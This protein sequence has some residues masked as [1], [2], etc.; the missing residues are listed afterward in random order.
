MRRHQEGV[1]LAIIPILL[2]V[3]GLF[4]AYMARSINQPDFYKEQTTQA[5]MERVFNALSAHVQR[6]HRL[7][8]PAIPN[9]SGTEPFG[10]EEGSGVNGSTIPASCSNTQ[11]L[12]PFNT[13]GLSENDTR[14]DWGYYMT[15]AISPA[16]AVNPTVDRL[17]SASGISVIT[18]RLPQAD[19]AANMRVH[20]ACRSASWIE[21]G[22]TTFV[23]KDLV[24][25]NID[26]GATDVAR[27]P[28]KARF[29]CAG[30]TPAAIDETTDLRIDVHGT[31]TSARSGNAGDYAQ[32]QTIGA[33]A[34]NIEVP[35]VALI[36]HGT[37]GSG[38]YLGGTTNNRGSVSAATHSIEE[39]ENA[40]NDRNFVIR[41]RRLGD[42]PANYFDDIVTF[43]TQNQL[44]KQLGRS[45]CT[46][47]Y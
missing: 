5:K 40:N 9:G 21:V 36:S 22:K 14:D 29:C 35:V 10:Y 37:N 38:A 44:Y 47:P 15:Y 2:I 28:W 42:T 12:V 17:D 8:C 26:G 39:R 1:V 16:F 7:P 31:F 23:G 27:N 20:A 19:N 43:R 45:D 11:G 41:P 13:L 34:S 33:A 6:F 24:T 4:V 18:D 32:G 3:L 46:S 30:I 25:Y